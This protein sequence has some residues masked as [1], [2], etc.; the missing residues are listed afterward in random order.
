MKRTFNEIMTYIST[1]ALLA[2]FGWAIYI[3]Y[4]PISIIAVVEVALITLYFAAR[5]IHETF[6][7]IR[8][9]KEKC[10]TT[11]QSAKN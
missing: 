4:K 5:A 6:E 2:V 3:N 7:K 9:G 8:K 1:A 11:K 10:L